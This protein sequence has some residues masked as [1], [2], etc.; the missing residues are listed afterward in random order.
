MVSMKFTHVIF[1][2]LQSHRVRL[3]SSPDTSTTTWRTTI[4]ASTTTTTTPGRVRL[5]L[6]LLAFIIPVKVIKLQLP[7]TM[8][9]PIRARLIRGSGT[10]VVRRLMQGCIVLVVFVTTQTFR[11]IIVS[12]DIHFRGDHCQRR[13]SRGALG[14]IGVWTREIIEIKIMFCTSLI[15]G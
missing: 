12:K 1:Q 10:R 7:C 9:A 8:S 11:R 13:K 15:C 2:V 3:A 4:G 14:E 6:G 5:L